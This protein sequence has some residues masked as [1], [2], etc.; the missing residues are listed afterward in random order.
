VQY[1]QWTENKNT[2]LNIQISH[3]LFIAFI[4]F[5]SSASDDSAQGYS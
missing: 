3:K 4:L 2:Y 1:F 5:S